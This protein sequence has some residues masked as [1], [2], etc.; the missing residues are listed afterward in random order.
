MKKSKKSAII[1][2]VTALVAVIFGVLTVFVG[3]RTLLGFFDPGYTVFLPLLIFNFLMGFIYAG[4]GLLI[5]K[6]YPKALKAARTVFLLNL[7]VFLITS[8]L[9]LSSDMVAMESVI[10]MTFRTG[11]WFAIFMVIRLLNRKK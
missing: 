11:V 4:T 10:A 3:G 6:S 7:F 9:Y 2:T 1:R 8:I 5:W